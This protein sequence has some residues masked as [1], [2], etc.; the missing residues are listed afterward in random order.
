MAQRFHIEY[1]SR[2][3]GAFLVWKDDDTCRRFIPGPRGLFYSDYKSR[4]ETILVLNEHEPEAV[5]TVRNNLTRYNQRPV[6]E[7]RIARSMQETADLTTKV[8]LRMIDNKSLLNSPITRKCVRNAVNIWGPSVA[9]LKGKTTRERS[10]LVLLGASTITP[11]PPQILAL[12]KSVTLG[13]DI[14]KVIGLPFLVSYS[15]MIKFGTTTELVNTKAPTIISAIILILRVYG[16]R[17]FKVNF[18]ATDNGFT[19]LQRN[20]AFLSL[21]VLFNVTSKDEHEPYSERFI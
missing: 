7:A 13:V 5:N 8:M 9:N 16:S 17:C 15:R 6:N 2:Q 14:M 3:T 4:D 20:E 11:L 19:P 1:D 12:H 18:M 21:G 10:R